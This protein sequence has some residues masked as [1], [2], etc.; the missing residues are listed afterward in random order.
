M[1]AGNRESKQPGIGEGVE[2]FLLVVFRALATS[3]RPTAQS[4][5]A[6]HRIVRIVGQLITGYQSRPRSCSGRNP[7]RH[8]VYRLRGRGRVGQLRF[9]CDGGFAKGYRLVMVTSGT[10]PQGAS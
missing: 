5:S 1:V 8:H 7:G 2:R 4:V 10:I 6:R 9:D 3:P